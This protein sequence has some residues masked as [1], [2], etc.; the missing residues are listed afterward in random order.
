MT[1]EQKEKL[2][3]IFEIIKDQLEPETEYYSYQTYRSRQSFYKVTEGRRDDNVPKVI[4]WKNNRENLEGTDFNILEVLYDFNRNSEYD[5]ITF[6][7]LSKEKG[8]TN[9]TVDAELLIELMKLALFSDI[10]SG[11]GRREESVI[12]IIPSKNSDR[13]NLDI[14]TKIHDADG[15]V[16][17]SDFAEVEKY[18]DCLYHRLDQ[19]LEVIYTSASENAIE[20]LTVPEISGLTSLYAPVED[21]SLEASETEK[22]YEFLESWSDAK[23]AKALEV[24]NTNPFLK[25]NVEKRY[26]KFI[27]SRV[28]ND[29]GLDAFVKAGLTRKEF[30]L[31]NGKDFDK[32][33]ISF[34]YFQE[35]E[36]QLVVNFIGSLVMNYLD[37]D[38]FK[39]EAQAAET[40]EDLLKIYSYAADIVKKGILEEAKTNPDGWFSK[41][42]IKF[43]NLKV[44]DVLFEKTDFTI[45][46]LNCL[47]AFIFYLG[48]NTHRSVYLDIFQSTCKELTE[49]FWLLPSV[50]QSSWGDTELKLP[51]YPLKFSRTAIYRLGDGKRWRNKS[52]PEKSSK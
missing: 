37:I 3:R 40:E 48:I 6:F 10:E 31:L 29:A 11:S 49:F 43:A 42:S 36:C 34:S 21:L 15:G 4:H 19:K 2:E 1:D 46:N 38:Q 45:P 33:F 27:R 14:F 18:V 9:K 16:R 44:Y 20:I 41:L 5:K 51:E 26:L 47:K 30:N 22:V 17:E 12:K 8:F 7:T 28:G 39:K 25:A 50:P 52:F 35:E 32:N 13:L 23:I 24:I